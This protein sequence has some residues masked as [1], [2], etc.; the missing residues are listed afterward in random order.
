MHRKNFGNR[1][2]IELSIGLERYLSGY[3]ANVWWLQSLGKTRSLWIENW[4][5]RYPSFEIMHDFQ[6]INFQE[7]GGQRYTIRIARSSLEILRRQQV[8]Q[9]Y[10]YLKLMR[11]HQKY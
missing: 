3:Q 11:L 6:V 2:I 7:I 4:P 10:H 1:Y 5:K 8:S 9:C